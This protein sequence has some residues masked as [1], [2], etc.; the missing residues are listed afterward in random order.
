[1]WLLVVVL[2]ILEGSGLSN[3]YKEGGAILC[4]ELELRMM[5][6]DVCFKSDFELQWGQQ[7]VVGCLC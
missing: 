4:Q 7:S 6:R 3:F 5:G 2:V 1:M